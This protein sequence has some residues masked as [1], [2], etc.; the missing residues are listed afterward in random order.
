MACKRIIY[1]VRCCWKFFDDNCE[2]CAKMCTIDGMDLD[3]DLFFELC[4]LRYDTRY[5]YFYS[6]TRYKLLCSYNSSSSSDT[7]SEEDALGSR[8]EVESREVYSVYYL[9]NLSLL[10]I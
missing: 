5:F 1:V 6:C 3:L 8:V 7:G 10:S 4:F 2:K 9:C